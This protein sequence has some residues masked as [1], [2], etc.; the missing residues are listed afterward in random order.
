[1]LLLCLISPRTHKCPWLLVF[2]RFRKIEVST[3]GQLDLNVQN[4]PLASAALGKCVTSCDS[5][6]RKRKTFPDVS[7]VY[8]KMRTQYL[9]IPKK[10]GVNSWI[11]QEVG[12]GIIET[13]GHI[14]SQAHYKDNKVQRHIM[15]LPNLHG[16]SSDFCIF[17]NRDPVFFGAESQNSSPRKGG[18][19]NSEK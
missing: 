7:V 17:S 10:K 6:M 1:M 18:E 5:E 2:F 4:L 12:E 9:F 15:T 14:K 11:N 8:N 19:P 13:D 3:L 16:K